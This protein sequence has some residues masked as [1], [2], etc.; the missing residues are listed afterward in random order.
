MYGLQVEYM[1]RLGKLSNDLKDALLS[2]KC[3]LN[4]DLYK[5]GKSKISPLKRFGI[6]VD[7]PLSMRFS[8][9]GDVEAD[10]YRN[11]EGVMF[12]TEDDTVCPF[13]KMK[14]GIC[15]YHVGDEPRLKPIIEELER[16]WE[17]ARVEREMLAE[18]ERKAKE[19]ESVKCQQLIADAKKDKEEKI[20]AA[21]KEKAEAAS[22]AL[23]AKKQIQKE[24]ELL[25]KQKI[26]A[27]GGDQTEFQ[28]NSLKKNQASTKE[29]KKQAED[30][31]KVSC[32][33]L[34]NYFFSCT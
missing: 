26:V 10:V 5:M 23:A 13:P 3:Y 8:E 28:M 16:T 20:A 12:V 25:K 24:R 19:A 27:N 7:G 29:R 2:V 33:F 21:K 14:A 9:F 32:S 15:E 1:N 34:P 18:Q 17:G 31:V 4:K 11:E 30:T 6:F 22:K